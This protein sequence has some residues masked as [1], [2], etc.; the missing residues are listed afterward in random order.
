MEETAEPQRLLNISTNLLLELD[1][2]GHIAYA[3]RRAVHTWK[4][5][6]CGEHRLIDYLDA[7]SVNV[8]DNAV[9][10]VITEHQPYNFILTDHGRLYS[11]SLYP[12]ISGRLSLCMED[13]TERHEL[14]AKLQRIS[15]RLEFAEKTTHLGYW[16]LDIKTHK[17]YWSAEM[18]R[19]FGIDS[20]Q[21]SPRRNL[22][23]EQMLPDDIPVYKAKLRELLTEQK[24]V[25]GILR[26]RHTDNRLVYCAFKASIVYD[27]HRR[28]IAGTFQDITT[29]IET[30]QEL[31]WAKQKAEELSDAKSYFLAQASHDLRQPM[32]ALKIFIATLMEEKL[33]NRQL[34][35][36]KKIE[37]SADNLN[38]LLDNLLDLSKIEAGGVEYQPTVF[39]IGLLVTGLAREYRVLAHN[40]HIRFNYVPLHQYVWSDPILI[41]RII[42][43]LL[44]NA[45]KYTKNKILLGIRNCGEKV[46]ILVM[47]NGC[48][49]APEDIDNIFQDFYQSRQ[50]IRQKKQGAGLGLA[51]VSRIATLLNTEITVTSKPGQG[52]CFSFQISKTKNPL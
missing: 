6:E 18:Y 5:A 35:L 47:D 19:I 13:I 33:S 31:R 26:I 46:C 25:E 30:Q 16:E 28:L 14:S 40:R 22:I 15:Q 37:D 32:Q 52:S 44:N 8:F 12:A 48:G 4:I 1:T 17:I 38:S 36:V 49:I 11:A 39:D 20:R 41:E 42:R 27:N 29:L 3:N 9:N 24:P 50:H 2:S 7:V 21:I 51:I 23:R 43:N 34:K 10:R 45:F